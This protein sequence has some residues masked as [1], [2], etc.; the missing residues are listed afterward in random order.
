MRESAALARSY[1]VRLHTHLAENQNDVDYSMQVFGQ[2]PGDYAD[3]MGWVGDDVWHAHCVKLN[4][5]EIHLFGRT[6]TGVCHCPSSN[7]RLASGIAPVRQMRDAGVRVGLGV[8]GSASNDSG[9]LLTEA[10]QAMLLQR[11]ARRTSSLTGWTTS[12]S[13]ARCTTR[14]RRWSSASRGRSTCRSSMGGS[15][16]ATASYRRSTCRCWSSSITQFHTD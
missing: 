16:S 5:D 6:G 14:W 9:H 12:L 11:V 3:A 10:R 13:P 2:R 7:M 8:D 15:S 1:G 4:H